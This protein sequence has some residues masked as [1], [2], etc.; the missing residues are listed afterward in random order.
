MRD[1]RLPTP[2][3]CGLRSSGFY[4]ALFG[5]CL[6]TFR[7][8]RL[9]TLTRIELLG[10]WEVWCRRKQNSCWKPRRG[11]CQWTGLRNFIV[12]DLLDERLRVA[13]WKRSSHFKKSEG[14][15]RCSQQPATRP[16]ESLG[17]ADTAFLSV[18]FYVQLELRLRYHFQLCCTVCQSNSPLFK[19]WVL[20]K[21]HFVWSLS[22]LMTIS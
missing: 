16:Y 8:E 9:S 20:W 3:R 17:R 14:S 10:S 11:L 15:W 4:A 6:P 13:K 1:I 12:T 21:E 18:Y 7:T 5:S 19:M 2:C 22:S